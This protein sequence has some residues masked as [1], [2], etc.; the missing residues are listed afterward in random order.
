MDRRPFES[1]Y[2]QVTREPLSHEMLARWVIP[3]YMKL[4]GA[5]V[6][7]EAFDLLAAMCP[8]M[9]H[10]I[11]HTLLCQMNWR[12]R[13]VGAHVAAC[14]SL[15]DLTGWIGH[16]LLRSD[17]CYAGRGYCVALAHFNTPESVGF[18]LEYLQYYLTR[19]DLV[20]DQA[21]AMS[22]IAYLDGRNGTHHLEALMPSWQAFV[23]DKP[24]WDLD[25][26][27]ANFARWMDQ[28]SLLSARCDGVEVLSS[29]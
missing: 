13:L 29:R 24:S 28:V 10:D 19:S 4:L 11:A 5:G 7:R 17:L 8:E 20:Y 27:T 15:R 9:T 6:K 26:A 18:L 3:L 12:P 25:R 2:V 23:A 14:K 1:L 22:A 16:L 21:D